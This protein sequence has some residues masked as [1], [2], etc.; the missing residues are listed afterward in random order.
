[1]DAE[2]PTVRQRLDHLFTFE[3]TADPLAR[4]IAEW[5]SGDPPISITPAQ[6]YA[7]LRVYAVALHRGLE[8]LADEIDRLEVREG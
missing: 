4:R 3:L 7:A 2:G 1:M 5:R 6:E 8:F